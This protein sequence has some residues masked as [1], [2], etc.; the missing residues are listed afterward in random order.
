M[1]SKPGEKGGSGHPTKA[2]DFEGEG[3]PDTKQAL[4]EDANPG[5]DDVGSNV[6]QSKMPKGETVP[7]DFKGQLGPAR[8]RGY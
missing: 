1:I 2:R 4:Y 7:T 5:N 6:R 3:G 8:D